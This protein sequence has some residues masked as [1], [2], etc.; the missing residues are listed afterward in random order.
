MFYIYKQELESQAQQYEMYVF[1]HI[2]EKPMLF[3]RPP[4]WLELLQTL[5]LLLAFVV[6]ILV[7][8]GK[9]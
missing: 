4:F 3:K 7:L 5:G 2:M 9:W 6:V 1:D 8:F